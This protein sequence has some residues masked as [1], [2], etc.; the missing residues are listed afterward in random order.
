M[1]G[2]C[3]HTRKRSEVLN[4]I[5]GLRDALRGDTPNDVKQVK[6]NED[7]PYITHDIPVLVRVLTPPCGNIQ[8]VLRPLQGKRAT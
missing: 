8:L 5:Y 7:L 4:R 6:T 1:N 2:A 3:Y